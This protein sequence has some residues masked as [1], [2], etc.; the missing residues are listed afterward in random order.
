MI[1]W[2]WKQHRQQPPQ[3]QH[4][5]QKPQSSSATICIIDKHLLKTLHIYSGY[6]IF[7]IF[8]R[9]FTLFSI[10]NSVCLFLHSHLRDSALH[11]ICVYLD[12]TLLWHC[13]YTFTCNIDIYLTLHSVGK[14]VW[15]LT[16]D[17][18]KI[19]IQLWQCVLKLDSVLSYIV[20]TKWTLIIYCV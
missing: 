7:C 5:Q 2:C 1:D 15:I 19:F 9:Y 12:I 14:L 16:R 4:R 11:Y 3:Q 8:A 6:Q 18:W 17:F 10:W 20:F 13:R